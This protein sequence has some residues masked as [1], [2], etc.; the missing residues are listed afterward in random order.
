MSGAERAGGAP[1]G[2]FPAP[3]IPVSL[4]TG[5]LLLRVP[6]ESDWRPLHAYYGDAESVRHTVGTPYTEGQTWRSV[7]GSAG[8]WIWRGYGPYAVVER[9]GGAVVG[10]VGLWYPGDWPEPEIMWALVPSARGKGYATE[11]ARAVRAMAR[12]HLP[13]MR[14]ISLISVG[15]EASE[16]VA[17]AVGARLEREMEFRGKPARIYRHAE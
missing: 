17:L 9:T 15:N 2:P 4:E 16:R 1:T 6:E 8:H 5:R 7:A 10:L 13:T 14:P 12:E 3:L 11:A